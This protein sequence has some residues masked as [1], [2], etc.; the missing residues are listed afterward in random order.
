MPLEK[1]GKSIETPSVTRIELG[2]Y[3]RILSINGSNLGKF[4]T[5]C[6]TAVYQLVPQMQ[7]FCMETFFRLPIE[8]GN[9]VLTPTDVQWRERMVVTCRDG[10]RGQTF[11]GKAKIWQDSRGNRWKATCVKRAESSV[12]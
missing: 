1:R 8:S 11:A 12:Q 6:M 7:A 5:N 4:P 2:N 3:P 9:I 10:D